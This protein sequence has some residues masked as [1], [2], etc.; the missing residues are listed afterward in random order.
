MAE[1]DHEKLK[2]MVET[3]V[4]LTTTARELSER[5]RDYYDGHQWTAE[6]VRRLRRR[7]GRRR[8]ASRAA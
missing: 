1:L 2:T 4:D 8:A 6:E 3:A 7:R 5:D